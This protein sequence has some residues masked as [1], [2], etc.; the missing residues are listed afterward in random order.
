[1]QLAD[2]IVAGKEKE[3]VDAQILG[4]FLALENKRIR[5]LESMK[6]ISSEATYL[7]LFTLKLITWS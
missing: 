5:K 1:M 4:G 3:K 2:S 6:F 7:F